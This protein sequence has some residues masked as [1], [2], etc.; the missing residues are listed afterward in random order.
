MY[1]GR[2]EGKLEGKNRIAFPAKLREVM[3]TNLLIANWFEQSLVILPTQSVEELLAEWKQ[4]SRL[5]KEIRDLETFILGGAV[6]V[7]L[8]SQG[9][10]ILPQFLKEYANI[11]KNIVFTGGISYVRLWS[12]EVFEAYHLLNVIQMKNTAQTVADLIERKQK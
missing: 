4:E 3:G 1:W 10:F 12:A 5:Q 6:S 9:R 8:D 11:Q 2:F 7:S